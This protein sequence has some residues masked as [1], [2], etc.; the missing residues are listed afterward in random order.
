MGIT[1]RG[2]WLK[3]QVDLQ[4]M[5]DSMHFVYLLLVKQALQNYAGSQYDKVGNNGLS[6][7]RDKGM[8]DFS[9]ER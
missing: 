6:E 9:Q 8:P 3:I 2:G 1:R 7:S 4:E 5:N